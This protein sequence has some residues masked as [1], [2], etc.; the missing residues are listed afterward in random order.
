ME[1]VSWDDRYVD[2]VSW[3]DRHVDNVSWGDRHVGNETKLGGLTQKVEIW[4][5]LSCERLG[6]PAL[7]L[8]YDER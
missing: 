1:N 6:T 7:E 3:G 4:G 5:S 8:G 2:N